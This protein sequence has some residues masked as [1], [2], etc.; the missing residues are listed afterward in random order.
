MVSIENVGKF[1]I[2]LTPKGAINKSCEFIHKLYK[3][4]VSEWLFEED[5]IKQ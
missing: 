2:P 4:L 5:K 1:A 3:L